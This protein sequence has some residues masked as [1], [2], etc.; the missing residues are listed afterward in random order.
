MC[1]SFFCILLSHYSQ[2][3]ALPHFHPLSLIVSSPQ[4]VSF[5]ITVFSFSIL[6]IFTK[7][8]WAAGAAD[9]WSDHVTTYTRAC[10]KSVQS[11]KLCNM[12]YHL[13]L[14]LCS[15]TE[16]S[17]IQTKM[18]F[19]VYRPQQSLTTAK[20]LRQLLSRLQFHHLQVNCLFDMKNLFLW[21]F[22]MWV[23]TLDAEHMYAFPYFIEILQVQI[24]YQLNINISLFHEQMICT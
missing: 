12:S 13:P 10:A 19:D 7:F 5:L 8:L 21:G 2:E 23:P 4:S 11:V 22:S 3:L 1:M 17:Q 16:A 18:S 20:S 24:H 9:L 6:H 14:W 15:F